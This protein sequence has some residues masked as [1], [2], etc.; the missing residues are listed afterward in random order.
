M[1]KSLKDLFLDKDY[2]PYEGVYAPFVEK[3]SKPENIVNSELN[4]NRPL[5]QFGKTLHKIY[6]KYLVRI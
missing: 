1:P 5:L 2:I 3:P 6:G 4:G